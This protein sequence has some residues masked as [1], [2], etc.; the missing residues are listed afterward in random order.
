M[1][2][3]LTYADAIRQALS[4]A[5]T[6]DESVV[7]F[8]QA[9]DDVKPTYGTTKGLTETFGKGRALNTP[10][11]EEG[12][13]GVAI[14]MALAGLRPVLT[15]IRA[16]FLLLSMNQL[17][18]IAAKSPWMWGPGKFNCPLVVRAIIGK[19]WGQG[20]QHSQG[21]YPQLCNVPGLTVVA[22]VKP[23]DAEQAIRWSLGRGDDRWPV[24]G[25]GPTIIFEHRLLHSTEAGQFR[26]GGPM[27][28]GRLVA[29]M[30]VDVRLIG[31]SWMARECE[32]AA[33]LLAQSG[34]FA[35]VI[36]PWFLSPFPD[37]EALSWP[38]PVVVVDCAWPAYG[39]GAELGA[40]FLEAGILPTGKFRRLGFAPTACP[41]SP[42]LERE[43]YPTARTIA[44][45]AYALVT[46]DSTWEPKNDAHEE[47]F[48]GPF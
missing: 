29:A 33:T 31:V 13:T 3:K 24:L 10:L 25:N 20:A 7:V 43:F 5:M 45:A 39:F 2:W 41:T 46:G 1:D 42:S 26:F 30:T 34:V 18:N 44:K 47:M 38:S 23:E 6:E 22:P 35:D 11:S 28:W 21:V 9:V 14:G 36:Y 40:R 17:V 15:H 19:S 32:R 12:M 27:H 37:L 8:G 4:D 48:R 16:D